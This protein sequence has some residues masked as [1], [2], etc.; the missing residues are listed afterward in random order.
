MGETG[1]SVRVNEQDKLRSASLCRSGASQPF[2]AC[3]ADDR[4]LG[5]IDDILKAERTALVDNLLVA[6]VAL[7]SAVYLAGFIA[8]PIL[9]LAAAA[10]RVRRERG[11]RRDPTLMIATTKSVSLPILSAMTRAL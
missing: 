8:A 7:F 2:A 5:D 9:R 1:S 10:E 11:P 6:F 4:N 3:D